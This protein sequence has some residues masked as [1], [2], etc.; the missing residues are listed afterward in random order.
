MWRDTRQVGCALAKGQEN[1]ILVCRYSAAG[2]VE[3]EQAF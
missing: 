3:G 2:N 1:E